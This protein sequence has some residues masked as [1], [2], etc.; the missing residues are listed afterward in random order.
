MK[1]YKDKKFDLGS[2]LEISSDQTSRSLTTN[3]LLLQFLKWNKR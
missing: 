3:I 1:N 2:F